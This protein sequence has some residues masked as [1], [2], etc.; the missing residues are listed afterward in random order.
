MRN[1]HLF[2]RVLLAAWLVA[3]TASAEP[4][5]VVVTHDFSATSL[6]SQDISRLFLGLLRDV[7]GRRVTP[8]VVADKSARA[9]LLARVVG[10]TAT[11]VEQHFVKLELRGEGRWPALAADGRVAA[12]R[13]VESASIPGR[14]SVVACMP[15][16]EF[17]ALT[18][19]Q[20]G[21]LAV[22]AVD[23]KAPTDPGYPLK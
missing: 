1:R 20:Q 17:E 8:M 10:R 9:D 14:P 22:L 7:A 12:R 3:A 18:P 15:L 13:I 2:S 19:K 4:L 11:A 21:L 5:V 23:G 6:S 16:D